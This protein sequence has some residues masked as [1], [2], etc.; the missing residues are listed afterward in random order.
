M[1]LTFK[2]P[3]GWEKMTDEKN[4]LTGILENADVML[5]YLDLQFN[6]VAVSKSY[7]EGSGYTK[8]E[9]LIGKNHFALFPNAVNQSIFEKVRK[10]GK[11]I[12]FFDKPFEYVYQPERGVTYWNWTLA[13]IKD[14]TGKVQ[15]LILS[16]FETTKRK[17]AED[18]IRRLNERFEMAQHAAGIGVWDWNLETGKIEWSPEMFRL[19]GLDPQKDVSSFETWT[20][21]VDTWIFILHPEDPEKAYVN[22][23][24]ILKNHLMLDDECRIIKPDGQEMWVNA[25]GKGVYN[26]QN[27][28]IRMIG[29]CIDITERKKTEEKLREQNL[30]ITSTTDAIFSTD[31]SFVITSWNKAAERTFGWKGEEV[32]GKTTTE[33][34]NPVY[35]TFNGLTREQVVDKLM[36]NGCW[37]GEL[38]YHKKDGSMIPVLASSNV[39]KDK[40]GDITGGVAIVHD[41]T[42]RKKRE[43]ALKGAQQDLAHAQE[44]AKIGSWRIDTQHNVLIWSEQTHNIFGVKKGTLLTYETFLATVHPD[45]REYVNQRW[46]DALEGEPYDVEHRIIVGDKTKWIREKAELE[47]DENGTLL[48]GFGTSQDITDMVK[49]REQLK[50]YTKNLEKLVE[51]KTK[52]LKDAEKLITIGQTAGMVGHDIRN[53]LQSI[54]GAIYL[55]KEEV[56]SHQCD[57]DQKKNILEL[58]DIIENQ[59][60]YIDHIVAD[61]QDFARTPAPQLTETDIQELITESIESL[62]MPKNIETITIFQE[63]LKIV[64]IDPILIKRVASNVL[65]NAI[66]AMPKRGKIIIRAFRKDGNAYITIEDTGVGISEE[67]KTKIFTPLF[68][69]KAKGQGFGLAVCKKLLEAQ[70]GKITFESEQG[71]GTTFTIVLPLTEG[72]E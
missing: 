69:T 7:A 9:E 41:I 32:I 54:E 55:A 60:H 1:T 17:K 44:V 27:K 45:D 11:P 52:Q 49:L 58:L 56:Q 23:E 28:P 10:T 20:S 14:R 71:K 47:F 12:T 2:H 66:Q 53:P 68:T 22:I 33:V 8:T 3:N 40:N 50:Y 35:P 18:A 24:E 42:E 37:R 64:K 57:T 31:E 6:F 43:K 65:T 46:K 62:K 61:L 25:L 19:F 34:F 26:D 5:A 63:D 29:I 67:N 39:V 72:R 4:I 15:G 30:V 13:P 59:T 70:N 36:S 48:G 21:S 38:I 51:E 16:L